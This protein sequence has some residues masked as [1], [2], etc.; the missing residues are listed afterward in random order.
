MNTMTQPTVAGFALRSCLAIDPT[1]A[2]AD[3][4]GHD[5]HVVRDL[6][7]GMWL[8]RVDT[9]EEM[10]ASL[11]EIAY[12]EEIVMPYTLLSLPA[13]LL[14]EI[15]PTCEPLGDLPYVVRHPMGVDMM[16]AA[17]NLP[18]IIYEGGWPHTDEPMDD[19]AINETWGRLVRYLDGLGVT[20]DIESDGSGSSYND[21]DG[22][23]ALDD[24]PDDTVNG[25]YDFLAGRI[26]V[27]PDLSMATKLT[28]LIHE[29]AHVMHRQLNPADFGPVPGPFPAM[30]MS[31]VTPG[32]ATAE[33]VADATTI[34][35]AFA[36]GLGERDDTDWSCVDTN[37]WLMPM[38]ET[39]AERS[40]SMAETVM[41]SMLDLLGIERH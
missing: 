2:M 1:D 21:G 15:I 14:R 24:A 6:G 10:P 32:M 35:A 31:I 18:E 5:F 8:V 25:Y 27:R 38:T 36:T 19:V 3:L 30:M 12:T 41:R 13:F 26:W 4:D 28:V 20:V 37:H 9:G 11:P 7:D 16:P 33:V 40:V 23:K 39:V 22:V 17:V 29:T 34:M